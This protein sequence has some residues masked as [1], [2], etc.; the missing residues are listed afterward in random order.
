MTKSIVVTRGVT[1]FLW[2]AQLVLGIL[3]WTGHALGLMQVHM[4]VGALFVIALWA[5]A[6][7][8]ARAGAPLS[9]VA[10]VIALG[11]GIAWLGYAQVQL[12]PGEHHSVVRVV[13]LLLGV[14]AMPLAGRVSM[15]THRPSPSSPV[16]LVA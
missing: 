9:L 3:F 7:V 6:I 4:A 14:L 12:L 13:H 15:V 10:L 16:R 8:C 2:L 1:G 11:A 5:L